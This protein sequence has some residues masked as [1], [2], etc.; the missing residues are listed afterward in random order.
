MIL[1]W[2][3]NR[4]QGGSNGLKNYKIQLHNMFANTHMQSNNSSIS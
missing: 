1:S 3:H 4:V 2:L